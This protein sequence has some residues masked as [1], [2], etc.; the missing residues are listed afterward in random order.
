MNWFICYKELGNEYDVQY[1]SDVDDKLDLN[2]PDVERIEKDTTQKKEV[3]SENQKED[4]ISSIG[5][6]DITD[7]KG[8]PVQE[9]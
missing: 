5:H 6:Q 9:I 8:K 1:F 4:A 3:T 7:E 2:E